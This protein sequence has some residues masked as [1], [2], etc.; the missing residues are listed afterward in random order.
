LF[1]FNQFFEHFS[2]FLL[3]TLIGHHLVD[4]KTGDEEI[5][6]TGVDDTRVDSKSLTERNAKFE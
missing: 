3:K 5:D 4:I 6:G 1:E 2:F